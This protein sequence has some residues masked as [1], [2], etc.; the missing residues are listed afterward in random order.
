MYIWCMYVVSVYMRVCCMS[1]CVVYTVS[2]CVCMPWPE[3]D[4]ADPSLLLFVLFSVT[5]SL[6]K[7]ESH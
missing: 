6:T 3:V 7:L 4:V 1:T 5:G 2:L